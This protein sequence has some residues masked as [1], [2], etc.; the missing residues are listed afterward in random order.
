MAN[1]TTL[2]MTLLLRRAEFAD[3][4]V[5]KEGE[6]GFNTKTHEFKIGQ[7]DSNGNLIQWKDLPLANETQIK[8][9]IE[10]VRSD[11]QGK[12]DTLDTT[13]VKDTDFTSYQQAMTALLGTFPI[14]TGEGKHADIK[15]YIDA[16]DAADQAYARAQDSALEGRIN[17]KI[18]TKGTASDTTI[19]GAIKAEEVARTTAIGTAN[20]TKE[21]ASVY[22]AIKA[23][24]YAREQADTNINNKIGAI[25]SNTTVKALIEAAQ[26]A[27]DNAQTSANSAGTAAG[28]A[29]TDINNHKNDKNN[30]H[31]V[32]KTQVGLGNVDN[33]SVATIKTEFT[34]S[35]AENNT[36][37]VTGGDVY[38]ADKVL[39]GKIS[40]LETRIGNVTNVMNFRGAVNS[41]AEVTNPVEGDVIT[42]KAELKDDGGNILAKSGS[43]WVYSAGNWVEIGTASA[44]DA[45]IAALQGRMNSAESDI[46]TL[47]AN[48]LNTSDFNT[49]KQSHESDHANKQAT[50]TAAIATAKGEAITEAGRLDGE[51]ETKLIG[52]DTDSTY[53]KTIKGAK[54]YA[55]AYADSLAGNYDA[56]GAAATAEQNAKDYADSQDSA[57]KTAIEG[58]SGDA[59]SAKTIAGAKKY[60]EEKAAAALEAA[61]DYAD[62]LADNYDESGAAAQVKSEVIGDSADVKTDDT[63]YG[64]KAFATDAVNQAKIDLVGGDT[65]TTYA[66]TIKGA[67][68]Y[69]KAYADA[70]DE[71]T[72]TAAQ[73]YAANAVKNNIVAGTDIVVTVSTSGDNKDKTVVSHKVYGT[74]EYTKPTTVSDANFVTGVTIENGHVTGASVKSLAEALSAMT[75][76]F[77][78]GTSAN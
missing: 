43:E 67:K 59:S 76:I 2:N 29:Q 73:T 35:I 74:G 12:I 46:T 54:D 72:L 4:C 24:A 10:T 71:A 25:A 14:G 13:Y 9:W 56:S 77:D 33:K 64:A 42:F 68:D 38:A 31:E 52:G 6:P 11:L 40:D 20:D 75:F 22:G 53:A 16:M 28:N 37:F 23:E 17:E 1:E 70:Q 51:L 27:A 41:F 65:D 26:N 44:S 50:I 21:T 36:G 61:E 58:T 18:G 3:T 78:G 45:A 69:A 8:S 55:K 5:L 39:D 32:T 62:S 30:P 15:A 48:K 63:I 34:G 49:W 57:L 19:Y 47:G 60:A 7:K 66:K